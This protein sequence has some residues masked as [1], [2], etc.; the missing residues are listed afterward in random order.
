MTFCSVTTLILRS[1]MLVLVLRI[2]LP[3]DARE[4][5]GAMMMIMIKF[6]CEPVSEGVTV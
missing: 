5:R 4:R 1:K 2:T 6:K 3:D